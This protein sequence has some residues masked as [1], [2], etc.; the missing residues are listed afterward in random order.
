VTIC[1]ALSS[2]ECDNLP[3]IRSFTFVKF[4][5]TQDSKQ[6]RSVEQQK[7]ITE[8]CS[9]FRLAVCSSLLESDSGADAKLP[10]FHGCL[11]NLLPMEKPTS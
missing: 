8:K 3:K 11:K 5:G 7:A 6:S 1:R 2:N 4:L 9:S 10:G